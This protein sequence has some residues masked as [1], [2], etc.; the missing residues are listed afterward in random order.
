MNAHLLFAN[1]L[2]DSTFVCETDAVT[3]LVSSRSSSDGVCFGKSPMK[4][5]K[6]PPSPKKIVPSNQLCTI[7][8]PVKLVLTLIGTESQGDEAL[9]K[10]NSRRKEKHNNNNVD[11]NDVRI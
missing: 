7:T 9:R 4:S 10:K 1:N 6:T 2:D 5:A 3:V 8:A 11:E